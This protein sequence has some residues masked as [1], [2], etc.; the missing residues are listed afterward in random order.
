MKNTCPQR[1]KTYSK[2]KSTKQAKVNSPKNQLKEN[3]GKKHRHI[4]LPQRGCI[5]VEPEPPLS[6]TGGGFGLNFL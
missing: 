1:G 4:N 2:V 3:K 6:L 5:I